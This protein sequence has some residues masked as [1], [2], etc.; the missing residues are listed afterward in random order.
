MKLRKIGSIFLVL[1][2][3]LAVV[4]GCGGKKPEDTVS[5]ALEAFK[6]LDF[7]SATKC[8]VGE[9]NPDEL[10]EALAEFEGLDEALFGKLTYKIN[11]AKVDGD[12][13]TVNT[14][15]TNVDMVEVFSTYMTDV[16]SLAFSE[17][18]LSLSE[19]EQTKKVTQILIDKIKASD[20]KTKTI[21]VDISLKKE[22]GEWKIVGDDALALSLIHI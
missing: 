21:D 8:F 1:A 18:F 20:A 6:K 7:E 15:I 17:E 5:T 16:I 2:L 13:A 22:D 3:V 14:S 12:T 9:E 4:A 10:K 11:E 19:E